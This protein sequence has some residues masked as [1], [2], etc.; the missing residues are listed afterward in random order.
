[1]IFGRFR[2]LGLKLNAPKF[3]FGLK[4]IPYL[5]YVITQEGIKNDPK[6]AQGIMN[7]GRTTT[8]NEAQALIGMFQ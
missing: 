5:G 2:A 4:Y 7:I 3:S 8:T 6:K 1:M